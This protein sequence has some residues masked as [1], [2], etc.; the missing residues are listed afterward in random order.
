MPARTPEECDRLFAERANAGD[1]DGVLDLYEGDGA[2]VTKD[3]VA[4]GR[5]AIRP[6]IQRLVGAKGRLSCK[7]TRVVP[8]GENLALLYNDWTLMVAGADG[9]ETTRGGKALE[10]VRRQGN[11]TWRF[12]IDDPYGRS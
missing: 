2:L 6:F 3:S 5:D 4:R 7:V 1:V 10:L 12:V 9:R 8:A 11:G